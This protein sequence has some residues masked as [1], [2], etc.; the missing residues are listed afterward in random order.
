MYTKQPLSS[1]QKERLLNERKRTKWICHT[2]GELYFLNSMSS[3]QF[4]NIICRQPGLVHNIKSKFQET[5]FL[6]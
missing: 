1:L 6:C 3:M 4:P 5:F 2:K